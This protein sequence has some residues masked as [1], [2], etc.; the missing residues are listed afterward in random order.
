MT[1]P[2]RRVAV[3]GVVGRPFMSRLAALRGFPLL[4]P[5]DEYCRGFE[6]VLL[7]A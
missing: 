3:T 4:V 2:T 6:R 7:V 1:T 5:L